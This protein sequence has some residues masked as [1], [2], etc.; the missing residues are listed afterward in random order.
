MA[1]KGSG[2]KQKKASKTETGAAVVNAKRSEEVREGIKEAQKR[3]EGGYV[4]LAKLMTEA[5]HAE[6]HTDW[7]YASF[8]E[9]CETELDIRYRKAR[10]FIEIW[11]KVKSLDLPKARVEKLGWTKMKEIAQVITEKNAKEWMDKAEKMS[12]RDLE[13]AVRIVRKR[14]TKDAKV[15]TIVTIS[16]KMGEAEASTITEALSEAKNLCDSTDDAVALEMICQDWLVEK[17]A[18]PTRQSLAE[19]IKY[20]ERVFGVE[21]EYKAHKPEAGQKEETKEILDKV[22][23]KDAEAE[24]IIDDEGEEDADI[25]DL[26]GIA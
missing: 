4:D 15:P 25:D 14:D 18:Q 5:Y 22:N 23:G 19:A 21:I 8:E 26:L 20:L 3:V 24:E 12:S 13:E 10:Y 11:D 6:F 2:T 7:G 9:Y 16:I 1:K 17:G